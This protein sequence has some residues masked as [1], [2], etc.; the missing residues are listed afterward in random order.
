MSGSWP[1]LLGHLVAGNDLSAEDTA[2]AMDLV[3]TGAATPARVAAFVV[4]LRAKG[5]TAAEVRGMA[6]TMLAHSLPLEVDRRAVD[7]VGTGG[8]RSGSVNIS[9]MTAIVLASCGAV[10][11]KHGNRAA[12]SKCG[13]A[14]VLETLGVTIDLPAEGVRDCVAEVGIGFCFAPVF[15]PAMKFAAGAR[16][17]IGIPTAFN[18]LGPLTNPARPSSGLIGCADQRMAPVMAEVFAARGSSVLLVSGD[19]GMDEITTT[20]TTTCWVVGDGQ[21]RRERIVPEDLGVPRTTP[22]A[23]R[24]GDAE[25]NAEVVRRLLAGDRGPVRDAVV[26]NTAGALAAHDG[27]GEDLDV[28]LRAGIARAERAIDSGAAADLLTR[29]A[30]FRR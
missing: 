2:W 1:E 11:V 8:D 4:A 25:V 27:I 12:S 30:A 18:V 23:L 19:D 16:R 24:G 13:T 6:D 21:V 15:H 10:V 22:E 5:E 7:V 29:W 20:S 28:Q 17:E 26:L 9:T 14:D 3:M